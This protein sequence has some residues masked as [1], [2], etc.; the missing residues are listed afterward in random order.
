MIEE[1]S[2]AWDEKAR[3]ALEWR[4][5]QPLEPVLEALALSVAVETTGDLA[6]L[7]P[8]LRADLRRLGQRALL[9]VGAIIG[10][11]VSSG[12][13][14]EDAQ[15]AMKIAVA[16]A[17]DGLRALSGRPPE[18]PEVEPEAPAPSAREIARLVG[19]RADAYESASIA[20]RI[21][22][23]SS[24]RE[25]LAWAI[26]R[27]AASDERERGTDAVR[28]V[29][30]GAGGTDDRGAHDRL[31]AAEGEEMRDPSEGRRIVALHDVASGALLAE[32]FAFS[33]RVIAVYASSGDPVR[34][35][36]PGLRTET[37]QPGYWAGRHEGEGAIEAIAHV[38]DA[39]QSFRLELEST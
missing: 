32:V 24:A 21:R 12:A 34:V 39:R 20:R 13:D 33:D 18:P 2:R 23:S 25:E 38:G 31:A 17:R 36:G 9:H 29:R 19:G 3:V 1:L 10:A 8:S 35:E 16:L 37:M 22:A 11:D 28:D 5:G 27:A 26:R 14:A 30:A 4:E 7:P 6:E 15:E